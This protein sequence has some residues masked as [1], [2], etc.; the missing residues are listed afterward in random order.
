MLRLSVTIFLSAFLLFQVQPLIAKVILP[1]FGG[2]PAVWTACMLFFQVIL[3]GGY[4]YAHLISTRFSR[5][6]GSGIHI[7]VLL[8]SLAFLPI[9][10]EE[11]VWKRADVV[12]PTA[13]ILWLLLANVGVPY[14]LLS[15][16]APLVQHWF[17]VTYSNHSSY[18][19]YALSN[20]G[21]LLALLTY[22]LVVE[23]TLTLGSQVGSWSM[24]YGVF[25]LLCVWSAWRAMAATGSVTSC[26]GRTAAAGNFGVGISTPATLDIFLWLGLATAGSIM[27]LATTNQMSQEIAVAPFLW[28]VPLALYL[29][30]F[31]IT[32]QHEQWYSRFHFG[33]L[34]GVSSIVAT[35]VL[36]GGVFVP[37]W[38]QILAYSATMFACC[39]TC[40]GELYRL[41]PDPTHLTLFYLVVASG[42]VLGGLF[43]AGVAP[44]I[45]DGYWE[46]HV[47]L[48][49]CIFLT[50]LAWLSAGV[51]VRAFASRTTLFIRLGLML[52]ALAM[53]LYAHVRLGGRGVVEASRNFYGVLT[54]SRDHDE[55]GEKLVLTHGRVV[56]GEQYQDPDKKRWP[57]TYYGL[58][59]GVG[60]ALQHHPRHHPSKGASSL[61]VGI[62]GLG[63]GTVSA[64]GKPGDKLRFYEINPDVARLAEERYSYN[65][66]SEARVKVVLGDARVQLERELTQHG[67]HGFDVMAIDAFSSDAIP[68]HLIT[69]EAAKLFWGHLAP[70]GILTFHIS[71][72]SLDLSPVTRALTEV[73]D[74][75]PV[76]IQSPAQ[77]RRGVSDSTWVILTSNRLFLDASEV[78][79][80]VVPWTDE[81]RPPFLWTDDFAGLWQVLKW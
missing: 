15:S 47:G 38:V 8:I 35:A 3:L 22:P 51:S 28:V 9:M 76:R 16:T 57:T 29:A 45:F 65:S 26:V 55:V 25:V 80:A 64:Y 81:D 7:A 72:R 18:R 17:S 66:D 24:A 48:I 4:A 19:L 44:L 60:L 1:W 62:V 50:Q 5:R 79:E 69:R 46:Y 27:L 56:H 58:R 23:P 49:A 13:F 2:G 78:K 77:P 21:S 12:Q 61:N 63:V 10:P 20:T 40:H 37:L 11:A 31:I 41:R 70:D 73:C 75:E 71:N 74:C 67:S 14:F 6:T 43:V 30:T 32:F 68:I 53:V 52:G 59:S 39:M 34:M 54:I 33:L 36:F 42:G